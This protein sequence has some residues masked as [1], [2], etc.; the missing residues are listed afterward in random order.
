M[1]RFFTVES[2]SVRQPIPQNSSSPSSRQTHRPTASRF[3][4][5]SRHGETL[6]NDHASRAG[7]DRA[8]ISPVR[9]IEQPIFRVAGAVDSTQR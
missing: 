9:L 8:L 1:T 6:S 2:G 3:P 4:S 5:L 7:R